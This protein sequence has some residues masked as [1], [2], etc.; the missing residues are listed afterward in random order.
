MISYNFMNTEFLLLSPTEIV[1]GLSSNPNLAYERKIIKA[2]HIP[3]HRLPIVFHTTRTDKMNAIIP[4]YCQMPD[5]LL[6]GKVIPV[7]YVLPHPHVNRSK[8]ASDIWMPNRK[9]AF[10]R[11]GYPWSYLKIRKNGNPDYAQIRMGSTMDQQHL[12]ALQNTGF[13]FAVNI[14]EMDKGKPTK[15]MTEYVSLTDLP[16]IDSHQFRK[17]SPIGQATSGWETHLQIDI[18]NPDFTGYHTIEEYL[19]I[20]KNPQD[21]RKVIETANALLSQHPENTMPGI[22]EKLVEINKQA[23]RNA[24]LDKSR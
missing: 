2:K 9:E 1:Q 19:T 4:D 23:A 5:Y 15:I 6:N 18:P 7:S 12:L 11:T 13:V 22:F 14:A 3:P 16:V 24:L 20:T 21:R 8:E 17:P 10:D